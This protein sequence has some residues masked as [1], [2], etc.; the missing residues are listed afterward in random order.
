MLVVPP[1]AFFVQQS[2][3]KHRN[4]LHHNKIIPLITMQNELKPE[5]MRCVP[6][7]RVQCAGEP[8]AFSAL[9]IGVAV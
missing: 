8:S 2:S 3:I 9:H 4:D 6:F 7:L 1:L 5:V